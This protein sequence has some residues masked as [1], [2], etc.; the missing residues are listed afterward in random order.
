[1]EYRFDRR[2]FAKAIGLGIGGV[3][4]PQAMGAPKRR[5]KIGHTGITWGY[6][7][8]DAEQ[9][10]K[11]VA[12]LGYH[13]FESFGDVL[14]VWE[15]KGGL[16]RLLGENKL[17]LVSAYCNS[18]LLDPAKRK[19]EVA[20]MVRWGKLIKKC[21]GSVS[22]MGPTGVRRRTFNFAENK[23]AIVAGLNE[24]AKALADIG[25]TGVLHQHTGTC[26]ETREEVYAV[27]ESVDTRYVKFGPDVGQL[28]KG[29]ADPVKIVSDFK[30]L[31]EHVHLKDWDGRKYYEGYCPLGQGKVD[32]P[33]ILDLLEKSKIK[34]MIMVELDPP[35]DPAMTPF[36]TARISKD[37]L[38]L[39]GYKF[40]S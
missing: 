11:D 8:A 1:M 34:A 40:R 20:K 10:I 23:A 12:K 35:L 28:Q 25:I 36:E 39:K 6:K 27:M 30:S 33:K 37:Y 16:D 5:L 19:D 14:E 13:G 21:G 24:T 22:V 31:I 2:E 17:G 7:P 26:V 9:A 38:K 18:D 15:A 3:L 4:L 32:L 29:G